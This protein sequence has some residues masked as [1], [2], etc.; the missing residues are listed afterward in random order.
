MT[1]STP[2]D[3]DDAGAE[4]PE[5]ES[6]AA[7]PGD[8]AAAPGATDTPVTGAEAGDTTRPG[9]GTP[10]RL[11]KRGSAVPKSTQDGGAAGA[12]D[13]EDVA[14]AAPRPP[15]AAPVAAPGEGVPT[16]TPA[17]TPQADGAAGDAAPATPRRA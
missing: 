17:A 11:A 7:A 3:R 12:T 10:D 5:Q 6:N 2:D 1:T 15:A 14:A 9:A 16:G 13:A 8:A 4:R